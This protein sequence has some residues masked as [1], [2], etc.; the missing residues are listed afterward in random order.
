MCYGWDTMVIVIRDRHWLCY[1][2]WQ[3]FMWYSLWKN[4]ISKLNNN[5][6]KDGGIINVQKYAW[7]N[8]VAIGRYACYFRIIYNFCKKVVRWNIA[9]LW[10][11][12]LI[13]Y[14]CHRAILKSQ[15]INSHCSIKFYGSDLDSEQ[16]KGHAL[17]TTHHVILSNG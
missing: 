2:K 5:D 16:V 17:V 12:L 4:I 15:F 8:N 9:I 7:K 13:K 1:I 14:C 11:L 3:M 10:L 6:I